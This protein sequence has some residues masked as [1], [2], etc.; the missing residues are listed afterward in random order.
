MFNNT[1]NSITDR[2]SDKQTQYVGSIKWNKI[3]KKHF[4]FSSSVPRGYS[5]LVFIRLDKNQS[6]ANG[7]NIAIDNRF[8][9]SLKNARF[10]SVLTCAGVH[11]SSFSSTANKDNNF[12]QNIASL[13][14]LSQQTHFILVIDEEQARD[15]LSTKGIAQQAHQISRIKDTC[16]PTEL[17]I[18]KTVVVDVDKPANKQNGSSKKDA[19]L[20]EV[21]NYLKANPDVVAVIEGDTD[22]NGNKITNLLRIMELVQVR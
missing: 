15:I 19:E 6:I 4:N 8:H 13:Q 5:R 9:V 20:Q 11:D 7:T 12:S 3:G 10:S 22:S 18:D 14:A 21:A 2:F 17:G 16:Q 1:I